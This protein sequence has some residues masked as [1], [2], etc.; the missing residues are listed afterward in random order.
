MVKFTE[1]AHVDSFALCENTTN[2]KKQ[3]FCDLYSQE[4]VF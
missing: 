4:F 3:W 2:P 1:N